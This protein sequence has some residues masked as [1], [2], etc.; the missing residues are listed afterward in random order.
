MYPKHHFTT[1]DTTGLDCFD[2]IRGGFFASDG[3]KIYMVIPL[4]TIFI[5]MHMVVPIFTHTYLMWYTEMLQLNT[6]YYK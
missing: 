5:M 1:P 6:S 3:G 2:Y 4:L